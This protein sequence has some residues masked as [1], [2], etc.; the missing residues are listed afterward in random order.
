MLVLGYVVMKKLVFDLLDEV[1]DAGDELVVKNSG[2]EEHIALSDIM[3]IS[4]TTFTNP[5]RITLTLRRPSLFGHEITFSP[6]V[7]L[8]P[9]A[10]SP[11]VNELIQRV[12]A[13]RR[14]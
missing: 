6:P 14:H 7:R 9:F 8:N 4:Y 3:N 13:A 5:P 11:I 1:W 10:R 2:A 12:D